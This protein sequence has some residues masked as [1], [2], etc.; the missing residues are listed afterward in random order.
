M[1]RLRPLHALAIVAVV[2]VGNLFL[3]KPISDLCDA[4]FAAL[5]RFWYERISIA[6]I[7]GLS[8]VAALPGAR[9]RLRHLR[10]GRPLAAL[11]GTAALTAAAQ[12]W[13]LVSNVELIHFPQF[14]LVAALLSVAGFDPM[15]AWLGATA[16]GV[17]DETYQ[18]LV[19]YKGVAGTYFDFNDIFLNAVGATWG[20]LLCAGA[21][22]G[23]P[24][25]PAAAARSAIVIALIGAVLVAAYAYQP[26]RF[27]PPL[28]RAATGKLYR[29]ISPFEGLLGIAAAAGLAWLGRRPRPDDGTGARPA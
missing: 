21:S 12:R 11:L 5:G 8:V 1:N 17:L 26:P 7:G 27:S 20:V 13:L 2:T 15:A 16:A 28:V 19:I 6:A 18:H 22:S 29:V 25:P 23:R 10:S 24:R 4:A 3:H 9:R 14:A